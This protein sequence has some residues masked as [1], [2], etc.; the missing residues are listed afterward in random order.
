LIALGAGLVAA[1]AGTYFGFD[2]ISKNN[3]S[4]TGCVGN[5]CPPDAKRTRLDALWAGDASTVAFVA[6]GVLL[7]GGLVM[8]IGGRGGGPAAAPVRA[9]TG[10]VRNGLGLTV[11]GDF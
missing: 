11:E 9:T 2:A 5:A 6:S 3:A 8:Y 4:Q 1:G 7:A 10:L